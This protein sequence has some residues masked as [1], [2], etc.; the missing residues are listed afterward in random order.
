MHV[1][2]YMSW[3]SSFLLLF[4]FCVCGAPVIKYRFSD[5]LIFIL[6]PPPP[7][8]LSH[9]IDCSL[10]F[11]FM[12]LKFFPIF[13]GSLLHGKQ[14]FPPKVTGC[15]FEYGIK[16]LKT[17]LGV[18]LLSNHLAQIHQRRVFSALI[19]TFFYVRKVC[20]WFIWL[21]WLIS[22]PGDAST[23]TFGTTAASDV[24]NSNTSIFCSK[25][26]STLVKP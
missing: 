4:F 16:L 23:Q 6:P 21:L 11:F 2:C 9:N 7:S 14:Y 1:H 5:S 12:L 3:L 13:V 8:L 10:K 18:R 17:K 19:T 24:A 26:T 20:F 15:R 22:Q 25:M